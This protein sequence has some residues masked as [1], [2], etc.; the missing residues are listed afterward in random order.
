[1]VKVAEMLENTRLQP[2]VD[3]IQ[4]AVGGLVKTVF[5]NLGSSRPGRQSI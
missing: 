1:M 4:G 2:Q 3:K 5:D